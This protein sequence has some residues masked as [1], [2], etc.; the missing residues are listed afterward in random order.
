MGK[1]TYAPPCIKK[2]NIENVLSNVKINAAVNRPTIN[3][4]Q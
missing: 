1:G 3:R 2:V 4:Q